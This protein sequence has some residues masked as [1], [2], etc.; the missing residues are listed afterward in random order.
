MREVLGYFDNQTGLYSTRGRTRV[1][2]RGLCRCF[3]LYLLP[4]MLDW[5]CPKFRST[6]GLTIYSFIRNVLITPSDLL[7]CSLVYCSSL[8]AVSLFLSWG[9]TAEGIAEHSC[10]LSACCLPASHMVPCYCQF[11][12]ED[13]KRK[14]KQV[15][16]I[17]QFSYRELLLCWGR[18]GGRLGGLH[19]SKQDELGFYH[20]SHRDELKQKNFKN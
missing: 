15:K 11:Q 10:V 18:E 13:R 16:W 20:Q 14:R 7:T 1:G 3:H 9:C 12:K 6:V 2:T 5:L 8:W 17:S 19:P 4:F